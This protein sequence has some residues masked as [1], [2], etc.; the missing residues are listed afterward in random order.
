MATNPSSCAW[1]IDCGSF[2]R[3]GS[4]K[5]SRKI[6]PAGESLTR[7]RSRDDLETEEKDSRG[8]SVVPEP[9]M[10]TAILLTVKVSF[11]R[12]DVELVFRY[13]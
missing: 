5:V 1:M 9:L 2:H 10:I 11:N 3:P 12:G 6:T 7:C 4:N 13:P 8:N